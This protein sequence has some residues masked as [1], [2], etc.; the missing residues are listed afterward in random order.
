MLVQWKF[1]RCFRKFYLLSHFMPKIFSSISLIISGVK[2]FGVSFEV[3]FL[4]F[5]TSSSYFLSDL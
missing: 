3:S 1:K 5:A 2:P 4:D